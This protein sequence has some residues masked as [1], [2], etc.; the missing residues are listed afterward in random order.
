MAHL[1][2]RTLKLFYCRLTTVILGLGSGCSAVVEQTQS[3]REDGGLVQGFFSSPL[4]PF[5][6]ASLIM[7]L[8]EVQQYFFPIKYAQLCSLRQ[9]KLNRHR[10]SKRNCNFKRLLCSLQSQFLKR[11]LMTPQVLASR[12]GSAKYLLQSESCAMLTLMCRKR[13]SQV[14]RRPR[15]LSPATADPAGRAARFPGIEMSEK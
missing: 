13:I 7:S 1:K 11:G 9:S 4:K 8:M 12:R 5:S 15:R 3:C 6:S 14:D 10:L 2:N